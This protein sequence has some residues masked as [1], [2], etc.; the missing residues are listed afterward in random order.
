MKRSAN[1][2]LITIVLVAFFASI[3]GAGV[4]FVLAN[5]EELGL[6]EKLS[7]G[8]DKNEIEN[9]VNETKSDLLDTEERMVDVV[10]KISPSVVSIVGKQAAQDGTLVEVSAASG[11]FIGSNGLILTNKHVVLSDSAQYFVLF[12][13]G[14]ELQVEKISR[15]PFDDVAVLSLSKED[16]PEGGFAALTLADASELRV[17][18]RVI[19]VGNALAKYGNTVTEGIVSGL[20]REVFAFNDA[21]ARTESLFGLIQTDA[22]INRGNSGGPLVNLDGKVVG[23]NVAVDEGAN[24][25]GF[26]ISAE[27]LAPILRSIEKYGEINRPLFGARFIMLNEA[28]AKALGV[29]LTSGALIVSGDQL[30]ESALVSGGPAEKGGIKEGDV[31]LQVNGLLLDHDHPLHKVIRSYDPGEEVLFKIWRKGTV[32]D[33]T[34]TLGSSKDL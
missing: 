12:P 29:N 11:F 14:R 22:A 5:N 7:F 16:V 13:D 27:D 23:M 2:S 21:V 4:G 31:I 20:G 6:S 26:A 19:A 28:Q 9:A 25:I 24:S 18:Q 3:F 32:I 34:I 8:K 10:A 33:L 17:G 15:D 1:N 30:S